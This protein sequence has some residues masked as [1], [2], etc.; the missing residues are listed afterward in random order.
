LTWVTG[1]EH[2]EMSWFL[3]GLIID[4]PLPNGMDSRRLVAC[5]CAFLDFPYLAWYPRHSEETLSEMQPTLDSF[6]AN[7]TIFI[8]LEIR[9]HFWLPKLESLNHFLASIRDFGALDNC[10]TKYTERLHIDM[11]KDAYRATNHK[12]CWIYKLTSS[13]AR[14][15]VI[16]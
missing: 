13:W 11:A 6:H 14:T 15:S 2:E 8:N 5:L 7:K 12:D 3:L 9:D 4:L 1:Q 16:P 10:N